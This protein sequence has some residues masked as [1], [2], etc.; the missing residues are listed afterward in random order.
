MEMW[1][2]VVQKH[3]MSELSWA[4]LF[5]SC[6]FFLSPQRMKVSPNDASCTLTNIHLH[7]KSTE[8]K[9]NHYLLY[10]L[11]F[12]SDSGW[13]CRKSFTNNYI[14]NQF[15]FCWWEL[16]LDLTGSVFL[17]SW[18]RRTGPKWIE[19]F[20]AV[21][22]SVWII[23]VSEPSSRVWDFIRAGSNRMSPSR[24]GTGAS[25]FQEVK[26]KR[27]VWR[28]CHQVKQPFGFI[29]IILLCY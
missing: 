2:E 12:L 15:S 11:L 21:T 10:S 6:Q 27:L 26:G 4:F 14:I 24:L 1:R 5:Q 9:M 18:C 7:P 19:H 22:N 23:L 17:G 16:T 20:S 13:V 8:I 29:Q 28:S 3:M 25:E